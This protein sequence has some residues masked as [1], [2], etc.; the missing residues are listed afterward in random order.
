MPSRRVDTP[1]GALG[2][3]ATEAGLSRV[4]WSARGLPDEP[5]AVL[6][7]AAAQL[8]AYFAGELIAFDLPLD[9][10]GTE[11]QRH[12]WLALATIP[13]GQTVSYGEQS[14]RIGLGPDSARAVGAANGQNPLPI[15][16]PC[17]RV[18]G[19]DGSLTGFGGGLHIKRFLLEHEGALLP[20]GQ[21]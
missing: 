19:A 20:L 21:A 5:S 12:C 9:L 16:L 3:V 13:Y 14:R 17:H 10:D 6:D 15:V 8:E 18:I 4:R 1:I 2:L 11:F 7:D